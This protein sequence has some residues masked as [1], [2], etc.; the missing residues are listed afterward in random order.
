MRLRLKNFYKNF[1]FSFFFR[2][3]VPTYL[4]ISGIKNLENMNKIFKKIFAAQKLVVV[5]TV[6]ACL[7]CGLS[8]NNK[9]NE[10]PTS[11]KGT[12]WKLAG[13]VD[14]ETGD[15]KV[16]EPKDCADCYTLTFDTD[17]TANVRVVENTLKLD[18][19]NLDPNVLF[20]DIM[21]YELYEKDGKKY[22]VQNFHRM[23]IAA[24]SYSVKTEQFILYPGGA[25]LGYLLFYPFK[26]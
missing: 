7:L 25:G 12:K 22:V 14:E 13:I 17:Y 6:I 21:I 8:C 18:L 19:L 11:L 5:I 15:L 10:Q 9:M 4:L 24:E 16:L 26:L 20:E 3:F 23:V 1:H 2:I